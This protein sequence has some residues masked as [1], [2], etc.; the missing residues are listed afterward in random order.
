MSRGKAEV[1]R[2][3][4]KV[5][6][7]QAAKVR[8]PQERTAWDTTARLWLHLAAQADWLSEGRFRA[9]RLATRAGASGNFVNAPY[10]L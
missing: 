3:R 5:C 6:Q 9:A 7:K 4:A 8:E 2:E 1:Y 10:H